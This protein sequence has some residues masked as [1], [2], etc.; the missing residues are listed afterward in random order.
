[1]LCNF[2][3]N[4]VIYIMNNKPSAYEKNNLVIT[5]LSSF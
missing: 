3:L 5:D 2:T 4:I 1:M